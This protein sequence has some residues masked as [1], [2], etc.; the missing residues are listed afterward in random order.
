VRVAIGVGS[1]ASGRD[2]DFER[3]VR[4]AVEAERLGVDS[5]WTAEAWGMDAV[6]PLAFLAA[7][8]NTL[9]LGTGILQISART[10]SMTAMTA[11]TLATLS[12]DRFLLGLGASGPQVVEGLQGVPFARPLERMRE[13]IEIVRMALRGEPLEYRGRHHQLPLPGG[14]GKALR[15]SQPANPAIPIYLAT[16]SPKALELTGELADGWLGTSFTPEHADAHLSHLAAGAARAGRRLSDL[17]LCVGGAIGFADDPEPLIQ[18]R[19]PMLAFTLGA[20]GSAKT[21]FYNAAYQRGGFADVATE[22]QRLWQEGHREQAAAGIPDEM[23]LQSSLIGTEAM[24]RERIRKYR[25]VGIGTLR[26]EPLG[27]SAGERL[28]TLGRALELVR[29]ECAGAS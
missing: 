4:F 18:A 24:V 5:A 28:D 9:R 6:A 11:L 1:A 17:D 25:D 13:T 27:E 2:R 22:V 14:E 8:T 29:E 20:M 15:L 21:N 12:R 19:K 16:L 23:V 10:P 26:L 7:R 3:V